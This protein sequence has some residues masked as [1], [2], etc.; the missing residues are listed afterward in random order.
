MT[1][2]SDIMY[3]KSF[4]FC[5][6]KI[7]LTMFTE[8]CSPPLFMEIKCYYDQRNSV[9]TDRESTKGIFSVKKYLPILSMISSSSKNSKHPW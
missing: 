1:A 8:M 7:A 6:G 5:S 9:G 2:A 4:Y 3:V